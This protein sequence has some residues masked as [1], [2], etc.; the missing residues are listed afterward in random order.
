[1]PLPYSYKN[2]VEIPDSEG[3]DVSYAINVY[4]DHIDHNDFDAFEFDEGIIHFIA[5]YSFVNFKYKVDLHIK[6][7]EL[8]TIGYE[9]HLI[10]LIKITL[11]IVV[12]IA[13]FSGFGMSGFLWF[14]FIFASVFFFVNILFADTHVQK[15]I[16]STPLYLHLNPPTEDGYT[17]EQKKWLADTNRCP[18]C[19]EEINIYDVNCPEC[20][21]KLKQN[22]YTIPLDV[23]K[24]K[25]KRFK[26]HYKKKTK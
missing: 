12:F 15:I 6:K 25:E 3:V 19:G 18:A 8:I 13:F 14:S 22:Q 1:M 24:Y 9:I 11:A 26:Y 10:Q 23:T 2:K 5:D 17:E 16:K 4:A 20:G 21:L 7:D